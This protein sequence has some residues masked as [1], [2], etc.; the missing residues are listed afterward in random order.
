[1]S[2]QVFTDKIRQEIIAGSEESDR[3]VRFP[4]VAFNALKKAGFLKIILPGETLDFAIGNNT[5][6]LNLLRQ[7]G[8]ADLSVARIFEGHLNAL[9]LISRFAG[10]EQKLRFFELA[11]QENLFGIWNTEA[12]NGIKFSSKDTGGVDIYGEKTFCSGSADLDCPIITGQ[13][14][15]AGWQMAVVP[16]SRLQ[17][18]IDDSF[19]DPLG[20]RASVSHK[21]DF[22]GIEIDKDSLIGAPG[23]YYQQPWFSG[24]AI[25]F[26]AAQLGGAQS[27]MEETIQYLKTLHRTDDY[28]QKTRIA[29]MA[30]LINSGMSLISKAG[31]IADAVVSGRTGTEMLTAFAN[32]MRISTEEIANRVMQ[33]S[34]KS[35][36]ARGLMRPARLERLHRDLR[37][38]LRQPAPDATLIAVADH[39]LSHNNST[40]DI[41]S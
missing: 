25:R 18:R 12:Q 30:V 7:I 9:M 41:W 33:L 2:T 36:G 6:I 16:G 26:C 10:E 3:S 29:E 31:E 32:M 14:D 24:G 34:E 21:I 17:N 22:T 23:D 5:S 8:A 15:G 37:Y 27:V 38:Y 28:A 19:W 39:V 11:G 35:V 40:H 1:M 20:M 13:L 4:A